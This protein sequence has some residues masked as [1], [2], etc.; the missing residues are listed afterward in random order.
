MRHVRPHEWAD[1][2]RGA[3]DASRR[4]RM[5]A[6]A[7][8]CDRCA[9]GRDRVRQ[10]REA[11]A[12][13]RVASPPALN[14]EHIGARI[15]WVTSSERRTGQRSVPARWRPRAWMMAAGGLG[16]AASIGVAY[17]LF[18]SG[19]AGEVTPRVASVQP[20]AP[21]A[22]HTLSVELV[23][24]PATAP[25]RGVVTFAKGAVTRG[26]DA[27]DFASIIGPGDHLATG[28]D[29]TLT[30]QVGAAT[31]F[32]LGPRSSIELTSFDDRHVAIVLDGQVTVE[33]EHRADDQ[34]FEVIAGD[35]VVSV[36]GTIFR[37][38]NRDG[39]LDVSCAR[40]VVA[41]QRGGGEHEVTAGQA[42]SLAAGDQL[43]GRPPTDLAAAARELLER[44]V[45]VRLL[46]AW[47]DVNGALATSATLRLAAPEEQPVEVDGEVVGQGSFR[48]RVMSGRHH[49]ESGKGRGSWV[50]LRPG[51]DEV[52][53]VTPGTAAQ[54]P[55][56]AR[57][58]A[59][60]AERARRG[61]LDRALGHGQRARP[62]LRQLEK[63]GLL[64]GS[65]VVLDLGVNRDGSL[66]Y[67]NVAQTNLPAQAAACVRTV[68]NAAR[69]PD[70]PAAELRYRIAF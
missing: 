56:S 23:P 50:R 57:Q 65:F 2:E 66:G 48:A 16:L 70:G 61:Q 45:A 68:V 64:E 24:A 11:F 5:E 27:L 21:E 14:W 59:R 15:Y 36:R 47:T 44:D 28:A 17:L 52:A 58:L 12:R 49:V 4:A 67:L 3:V 30:V 7:D 25:L 32:T 55:P 20:A 63:Q 41:V 43:A 18:N 13:I 62:C 37:V 69:L 35:A 19:P 51:A 33:V 40:G 8:G 10:T 42:L 60:E 26:G 53:E 54:Q 38:E 31:G 22:S 39:E 1:V 34:R 6:H 46:P 9:R 29:G